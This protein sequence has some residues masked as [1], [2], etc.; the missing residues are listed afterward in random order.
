MNYTNMTK[1][2]LSLALAVAMLL[3]FL[4]AVQWAVEAEASETPQIVETKN[5]RRTVYF[6]TSGSDSNNGFSE[7]APKYDITKIGTY[8]KLGWNVKLKRGDVWYLPTNTIKLENITKGTADNPVVIGSYGDANADKPVIA[9]MHDFSGETWT[10][11]DGEKNVY[12]L[13]IS[14]LAAKY[15][16][17]IH[18]AFVEGEPYFHR[19]ITD[20]N[21][22]EEEEFCDY[23]GVLYMR[24]K[25]GAP[26]NVQATPYGFGAIRL[27]IENVSNLTMENIHIKGGNGIHP[28]IVLN[29]PSENFR[30][31][32]CDITHSFY[33]IFEMESAGAEVNV[34]PEISYCY[35]DT[36]YSEKE[37]RVGEERV[38]GT[39][40]N[41]WNTTLTE[42]ITM[43][44]G[45][46]G[47]WIHHN[48]FR[49]M[50]HAF[51]A[52]EN[53]D[54]H[55]ETKSDG[56]TGQGYLITGV[57]N[58]IIEDNLLEGGNSCYARAFNICGGF[59]LNGVNLCTNNIYR[60]N[61]VY[62]MT[63]SSHLNGEY[64]LIYSN[65]FSY[66]HCVY[67]DD[68]TLFEGKG[69]QPWAFDSILWNDYTTKNNIVVNNTFYDVGGAWAIYNQDGRIY[70]NLFANNLVVN[71]TDDHEGY[72]GGLHDNTNGYNMAMNNGFYSGNKQNHMVVNGVAYTAENANSIDGYSGN[73]SGD[74]IFRTADLSLVNAHGS[75]QDF[76]LSSGSPYRSAG[77]SLSASVYTQYG[78]TKWK[79]IVNILKADYTDLNGNA[80][81][82]GAP[83]I[84][85][86]TYTDSTAET[87]PIEAV[88]GKT[89]PLGITAGFKEIVGQTWETVLGLPGSA[90]VTLADGTTGKVGVAWDYT[91]L[92][93]WNT[94]G[95]YKL[96]G[97]LVSEEYTNPKGFVLTQTIVIMPYENLIYNGSFELGTNGTTG[98]GGNGTNTKISDENHV[99]DG[100]CSIKKLTKSDVTGTSTHL[101]YQASHN[102]DPATTTNYADELAKSVNAKGAGTYY[103]SVDAKSA[104]TSLSSTYKFYVKL[105][106]KTSYTDSSNVSVVSTPS[107]VLPASGAGFATSSVIFDLTDEYYW[108]RTDIYLTGTANTLASQSL[109]IDNVRLICLRQE[110]DICEHEWAD[111]NCTTPKTCKLCGETEGKALGH[112]YTGKVTTPATCTNAGVRT[113][114]CSGCGNSYTESIKATGHTYGKQT[115]CSVAV[116][117]STCDTVIYAAKAHTYD[118]DK[119]TTCNTCGAVREI[120]NVTI[121]EVTSTITPLAIISGFKSYVSTDWQAALKLPEKVTV[122]LSNGTTAE[123]SV[124]WDYAP[125]GDL[126]VVGRYVL[127]GT[128]VS[129]AYSNANGITAKQVIYIREYQNLL[130]NPSFSEGSKG[131]TGW[132]GGGSNVKNTDSAHI[133]HGTTSLLKTTSATLT[134][135]AVQLIFQNNHSTNPASGTNYAVELANKVKEQGAGLYYVSI[136]AKSA[137]AEL[138]NSYTFNIKVISKPTYNGTSTTRGTTTQVALPVSRA[139]F[140][141]ASTTFELT[142]EDGWIR[143]DVYLYGAVD[144]IASQSVYLDNAK[145]ICIR[146]EVAECTHQW[147]DATCTAPKTCKLCGETEGE[148]LEHS[149]N[150]VV[151]APSCTAG[152]YT[153]YTCSCGES[154]VGDE[155]AA[156]EHTYGEG[157]DRKSVV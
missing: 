76:S 26:T 108:L 59:N 93:D 44:D 48:T 105:V 28:L 112:S 18:R 103:M 60:R 102:Q 61:Q 110:L 10:L 85:A 52:I 41:H 122:K 12:M 87:K 63:T 139:G 97:T 89:T 83:T 145:L 23:G 1:R 58:C 57:H 20:Y 64:N 34:K 66:A 144:T 154:Y 37:G 150:A 136:D 90:Q 24:T 95:T 33:Y 74:P 80:Y 126:T 56:S 22:L 127:T 25:G 155:T 88:V 82:P 30:F 4:P 123:L 109:Y 13:D 116:K 104:S 86:I 153:T 132:G 47:A 68:G 100:S 117:C 135:T 92:G 156:L 141:T 55:E 31:T 29:A 39:P 137:A 98:W 147:T 11:V 46:D 142:G 91:P 16:M 79:N 81:N 124:K 133:T 128:L 113:Y 70:G 96:T 130:F 131:T 36:M 42:G 148:A 45:V 77:L 75:R 9:F 146:Q 54:R 152:G 114:T 78:A 138:T 7:S 71:Y 143:T 17:R 69:A 73:L 40:A 84:G 157:V 125:L 8:L 72:P 50:G 94:P 15:G 107:T 151:I 27:Q 19:T 118:D 14:S 111:A 115:D 6:S 140:A 53:L 21:L 38:E 2:I 106:S 67:N 32:R 35:F 99:S 121:T 129:G 65:V 5:D 3:S 119:D 51:I 43:R 149:Y 101:F 49:Q 62:D 134:G 120:V